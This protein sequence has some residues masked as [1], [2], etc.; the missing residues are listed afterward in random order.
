MNGKFVAALAGVS[1]AL[2]PESLA[3]VYGSRANAGFSVYAT[4]RPKAHR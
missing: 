3:S 4:V 1:L 2:V